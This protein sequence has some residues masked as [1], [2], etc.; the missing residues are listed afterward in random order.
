MR[1]LSLA[2]ALRPA[3]RFYSDK[4]RLIESFNKDKK[5]YLFGDLDLVP[6]PSQDVT[7]NMMV[8][9]DPRLQG[10]KPGSAEYK[11]Q[12]HQIFEEH[13][14]MQAKQLQKEETRERLKAIGL[15]MALLVGIVSAHQIFHHREYL[16][17]RLGGMWYFR[18]VTEA[19][20]QDLT[21]PTKNKKTFKNLAAKLSEDINKDP[22]VLANM[23]A[24][25]EATGLYLF[26]LINQQKLPF[27]VKYFDNMLISSV[28]VLKDYA[29]VVDNKGGVHH[30][31]PKMGAHR[32]QLPGRVVKVQVSGDTIYYLNH[33]GQVVYQ[34]RLDATGSFD[35]DYA[36]NWLFVKQQH[37]YRWLDVDRVSD[38]AA[39]ASHL[40][41]LTNQGKLFVT[42]TNDGPNVGQYGLP[43]LSPTE[44]AVV[45]THHVYELK[46]LN[47]EVA[48]H[49]DGTKF[50]RSRTFTS[51]ASGK[52]H[53]I[54]A[55]STGSVWT[56]GSNV[57][58]ECG[59]EVSYT[60][61]MHPVPK[62]VMN[63]VDYPSLAGHLV[64]QSADSYWD[65]GNVFAGDDTSYI[66]LN[67]TDHLAPS[68]NQTVLVSFGNGLKGQLGASRYLHVCSQPV[69]VRSLLGMSEYNEKKNR[70]QNITIKDIS[71]GNNHVFVTLDNA[72]TKKDVLTFGDNEFGQFG[73]GKI[74]KSCK[75]VQLPQLLE[76][77]DFADG[78]T[79]PSK[80]LTKRIND[81]ITSRLQLIDGEKVGR[82]NVEQV[83]VAGESSG[84]I[85][86]RAK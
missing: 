51:I 67:F 73:N 79:T 44:N 10:L 75:P 78:D 74:V 20:V 21:D 40:L 61:D 2:R 49:A 4:Y 11:Y 23:K 35:G 69:V 28:A 82:A 84:A 26:G 48:A 50:L 14:K 53:A 55:D 7:I 81:V 80:K 33:K 5:Q 32:V 31:S 64:S 42:K 19:K 65:V 77:S 1:C 52:T 45:P 68:N 22:L 8:E 54:A 38:L 3:R 86:Y 15:G 27:R 17:S 39:G 63:R 13:A 83:I 60:T 24:S 41:M 34:P 12:A 70:L 46:N 36:R 56:W 72:G 62:R 47:Y 37:P 29:V 85:F 43:S 66:Q 57:Y 18:E 16:K 30:Y 58:G 71:V 25:T 9:N 76:P 6:T 59:G